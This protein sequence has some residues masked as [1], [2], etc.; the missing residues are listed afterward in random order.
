MIIVNSLNESRFI[1]NGIQ[2]FKN[3]ISKIAGNNIIIFNCYDNKDVL[4]PWTSYEQVY[5]NG[6][7]YE[8]AETLQEAILDVIYLRTT[9]GNSQSF[10]QNNVGVELL[11]GELSGEGN[12][13]TSEAE[14]AINS[15][16]WSI[17]VSRVRTPV[18]ISFTRS[19]KKYMFIFLKGY[20]I[21]GSA[22]GSNPDY[23]I[24]ANDLIALPALNLTTDDI[25]NQNGTVIINLG[26]LPTG[27]YLTAA[28]STPRNFSNA[29]TL[30]EDGYPITYYFS[31]T[32]NSVLYFVQFVGAAGVYNGNLQASDL[33]S[34]T[35]GNVDNN[36]MRGEILHNDMTDSTPLTGTTSKTILKAKVIPAN[37]IDLGV[38]GVSISLRFDGIN[39]VKSAELYLSDS[40]ISTVGAS[41]IGYYTAVNNTKTAVLKREFLLKTG[42]ELYAYNNG[43]ALESPDSNTPL[44]V[45][46]DTSIQKYILVAVKLENS[47]DSAIIKNFKITYEKEV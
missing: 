1:L 7:A 18:I 42:N 44:I 45:T 16:S 17:V 24:S 5:I 13:S 43:T 11:I 3:Y 41:L 19:Q 10:V 40:N 46:Y 28:N 37:R 26:N 31:Y 12:I 38:I 15:L 34:T 47:A 25:Q 8:S 23:P 21:W 33:V 35:N 20:G 6:S 14:T 4:L 2:Y 39:N 27:N 36:V 32:K 22:N 9:L 29:G 30:N